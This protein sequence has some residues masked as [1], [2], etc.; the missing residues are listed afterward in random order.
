MGCQACKR[1]L[2]HTL[3]RCGRTDITSLRGFLRIG[4]LVG[5][6]YGVFYYTRAM[7]EVSS[8]ASV[9]DCDS[10]GPNSLREMGSA[11]FCFGSDIFKGAD[12]S[13]GWKK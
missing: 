11:R 10:D 12:P 7:Y 13:C 2:A 3:G 4:D 5:I 1:S 6:E 8:N 9:R